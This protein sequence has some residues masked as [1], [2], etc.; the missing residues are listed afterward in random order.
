MT[1]IAA[2]LSRHPPL[3]EQRLYFQDYQIVQVNPSLRCLSVRDAWMQTVL[4]CNGFPDL[5]VVILPRRWVTP[6]ALHAARLSPQTVILIPRLHPVSQDH[7]E[8]YGWWQL[9]VEGHGTLRYAWPER[10]EG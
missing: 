1:P 5:V 10:S 6:F 4:M 7:W 9:K 3:D 2:Y 8:F